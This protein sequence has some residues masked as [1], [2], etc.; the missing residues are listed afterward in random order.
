MLCR[1]LLGFMN[2]ALLSITQFGGG[3]A[4][5]LDIVEGGGGAV[6]SPGG[7]GEY[8]VIVGECWG[9]ISPGGTCA[10]LVPIVFSR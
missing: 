5:W 10:K 4:P 1:E 3:G 6:A 9:V 7:G 8:W 2:N